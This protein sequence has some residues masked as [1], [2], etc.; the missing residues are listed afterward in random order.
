METNQTDIDFNLGPYIFTYPN[1]AGGEAFDLLSFLYDLRDLPKFQ[2]K[3]YYGQTKSMEERERISDMV[4]T[5]KSIAD[6]FLMV[7]PIL[8]YRLT[9]S[10]LKKYLLQLYKEKLNSNSSY[11]LN[12]TLITFEKAI[13]TANISTLQDLYL[14]S[15][16]K[17]DIKLIQNYS[18]IE[19]IREL[20]NCL[21]HN[22]DYVSDKLNNL[23]SHWVTNQ[24]ISVSLIQ[25]RVS[26][27]DYGISS[28]FNELV[29]SISPHLK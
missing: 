11:K 15:S 10:Y 3:S 23:N 2:I 18:I 13:L 7:A 12:K 28:F 14:S 19:E 1:E 4:Y 24:P 22:H 5:T 20:N 17:V 6:N 29:K 8:L 9:E 21:K 26:D 27:F 25:D 16:A